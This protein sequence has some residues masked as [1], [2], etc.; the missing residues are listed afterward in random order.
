[1]LRFKSYN[2]SLMPHVI[3]NTPV[4]ICDGIKKK[5]NKNEVVTADIIS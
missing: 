2:M 4:I 5:R 3:A 1:M